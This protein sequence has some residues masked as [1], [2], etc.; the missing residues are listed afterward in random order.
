MPANKDNVKGSSSNRKCFVCGKGGHIAKNCF[1][2]FKT[3]GMTSR[4]PMPGQ[5][6]QWT[7]RNNDGN[8]RDSDLNGSAP[9]DRIACNVLHIDGAEVELKCGCKCPVV[10]DACGWKDPSRSRMPV[11]MG[12][13]LNKEVE[14]LRDTGCSTVVVR[15]SFVPD[16]MLTGKTVCCMLIDG[17]V[18]KTP[19]AVI[20]I[21]TPYYQ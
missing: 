16:D 19:V 10:A 4:M 17:T 11:A 9:P 1:Q 13:A 5:Y 21:D 7:Q 3:A 2:R 14:I 20:E 18:R 6:R 12:R 8:N 15:R